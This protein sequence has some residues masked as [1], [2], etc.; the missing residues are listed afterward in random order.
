M[1][2]A[3]TD[4]RP[5]NQRPPVA[6]KVSGPCSTPP[7]YDDF[8]FATIGE[9]SNETPLSVLSALTRLDMDP[10]QEAARLTQLPKDQAARDIS[11]ALAAL[12]EGRWTPMESNMIAAR[13]VE[14]LPQRKDAS[15]IPADAMGNYVLLS[16]VLMWL[17]F[18]TV[19]SGFALGTRSGGASAAHRDHAQ[20]SES[21]H[22][23]QLPSSK[24]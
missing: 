24:D 2:Q 12:P 14:L 8:L 9:D 11:C 10:W 18:A 5:G 15:G 4:E 6:H 16:L 1:E 22:S 23:R 21:I 3:T 13:L 7:D 17:I 19:W 20:V